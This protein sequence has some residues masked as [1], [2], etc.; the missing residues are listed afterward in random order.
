MRAI[1]WSNHIFELLF[2]QVWR[3]TQSTVPYV[4]ELSSFYRS[5][6]PNSHLLRFCFDS[7][8]SLART[9][10]V[11]QQFSLPLQCVYFQYQDK[12]HYFQNYFLAN[13]VVHHNFYLLSF[14]AYPNQNLIMFFFLFGSKMLQGQIFIQIYFLFFSNFLEQFQIYQL[15]ISLQDCVQ[16]QKQCIS[17][18]F[19]KFLLF[20]SS[21][22][23]FIRP[24]NYFDSI[25]TDESS[26]CID[27]M[28]AWRRKKYT[29]GTFDISINML[30]RI[31]LYIKSCI[32][33]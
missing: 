24:Y 21:T 18:P 15:I 2:L 23:H 12:Q 25:I 13:T 1:L 29:P 17:T 31:G 5:S 20:I 16:S 8:F 11:W 3:T 4:I 10:I 30:L 7:I 33:L 26:S 22:F 14:P 9:G 6:S 27:T 32:L 28:H 19:F